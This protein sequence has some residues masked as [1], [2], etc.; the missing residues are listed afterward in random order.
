MKKSNFIWILGLV[1]ILLQSCAMEMEYVLHRDKT[2]SFSGEIKISEEFPFI[3]GEKDSLKQ[4][5]KF[6]TPNQWVSLEEQYLAEGEKLPTHKDSLEIMKKIFIKTITNEIGK[7]IGYGM[8]MERITMQDWYK[9]GDE[10][11]KTLNMEIPPSKEEYDKLFLW[12]GKKLIFNFFNQ[13]AREISEISKM[14][15]DL[16]SKKNSDKKNK[17]ANIEEIFK[18]LETIFKDIK[19]NIAFRFE[20]KIKRIEGIN[21]YFEKIDD[22][23]IVF[24]AD[25]ES[26]KKW[27][28]LPQ[29]ELEKIINSKEIVIHIE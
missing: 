15:G 11:S 22:Y 10:Y 29:K 16:G 1:V 9:Y 25:L 28:K 13:Y 19:V 17:N 4:N 6:Y 26:M 3:S 24:R 2:F 23:T 7:E 18:Q 14:T 8:K 5:K 12:D 27:K 21:A 20:D